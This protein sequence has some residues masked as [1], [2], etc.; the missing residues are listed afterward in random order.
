MTKE[1][2]KLQMKQYEK[3][4]EKTGYHRGHTDIWIKIKHFEI[5]QV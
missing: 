2:C 1:E 4:I 3:L 5:N